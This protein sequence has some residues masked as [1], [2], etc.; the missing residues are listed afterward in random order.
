MVS[1]IRNLQAIACAHPCTPCALPMKDELL[2]HHFQQFEGLAAGFRYEIASGSGLQVLGG[3]GMKSTP[4]RNQLENVKG[5]GLR[6]SPLPATVR[7]RK[8]VPDSDLC[9]VSPGAQR[10]PKLWTPH[11]QSPK[12]EPDI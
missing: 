5:L 10:N 2:R 3:L 11:A 8:A 12:R 6:S 1:T 9:G 7:Q 4:R